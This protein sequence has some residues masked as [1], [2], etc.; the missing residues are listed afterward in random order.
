VVLLVLLHLVVRDLLAWQREP[1]LID[2]RLTIDPRAI[3]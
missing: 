3:A 2:D 1:S